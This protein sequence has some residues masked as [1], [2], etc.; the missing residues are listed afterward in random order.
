M[1]VP[2]ASHMGGMWERE[3]WTVRS[4][5]T[6]LLQSHGNQLDD[7]SLRTLMIEAEAIVN[8]CPLTTD[9]L[10]DTSSLDVLMPNHLLTMKKL[11][12]PRTPRKFSQGQCVLKETL[13]LGTAPYK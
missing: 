3:I 1:N 11:S 6:G 13:A 4:V 9:D 7:E 5:L 12:Y 10:A 8:S 2:H